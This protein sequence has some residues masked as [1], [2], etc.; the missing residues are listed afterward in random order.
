MSVFFAALVFI[1]ITAQKIPDKRTY[2]YAF[3]DKIYL[4]D[5]PEK[6]LI[7][8]KD[9]VTANK[10][11]SLIKSELN[12]NYSVQSLDENIAAIDL[13]G[14]QKGIGELLKDKMGDIVVV[15]PAYKYQNQ[16]MYYGNEILA[17]PKDGLSISEVVNRLGLGKIVKVKEGKLFSILEIAPTSDAFD[18]ANQIQESGMVKYSYPDFKMSVQ[19][20]QVIPNDTYFSNQFYLQ[21]TGQT[22][23]SIENHSGT[24]A[25]DI[26]AP[27]AWTSTTGNNNIIVA[28]LD[29]GLTP[30][31]PD[32]PN[33]RQVRLNGSNFADGDPNDP[34][35]SD[36]YHANH[37]N[38]CAGIIAATQ[39]N[40]EGISGIAPGVRIMPVRITRGN[41]SNDWY[42]TSTS[43]LASAI[44]FAW[45]SGAQVISNSWELHTDNPNFAPAIVSAIYRAVTQG[46][47]GLGSVVVFAAG[48]SASRYSNGNNGHVSFPSNVQINGVLTVG[49]SDRYDHQADYSP[50]S[51]LSSSNNQVI[52]IVAP[53]NKAMP[54]AMSGI[55]GETG[56]IYTIDIPGY[57]GMNQWNDPATPIATV[58]EIFPGS[59]PNYL[60]YTGRMGGTSASCPQVAAVAALILSLNNNLTQ[61]QVYDIITQSA[62][63]VGGYSYN[64]SGWSA[65]FGNGRLNAYAAVNGIPNRYPV[66]GNDVICTNGNAT[67]SVIG[68]PAGSAT[69]WTSSNSGV[70]TIS[71]SG[72]ASWA[73]SGTV[74]FTATS[75]IP[76]RGGTAV[77]Q[78]TVT[79]GDAIFVNNSVFGD[80]SVCDTSNPYTIV[81]LPA[82]ASVYWDATPL[83]VVT[84]NTPNSA[85]TTL[86]GT[87]NGVITLTAYITN[88]CSGTISKSNI[89]VTG[90]PTITCQTLGNG[91]CNQMTDICPS[92]LY[93]W[94]YF[95][96]PNY[97]PAGA[98][99]F[100]LTVTGSGYFNGGATVKNITTDYWDTHDI[101][102]FVSGNCDITVRPVNNCG[103]SLYVP[104][105]VS[106][107]V[108]YTCSY[109]YSVS[110][111]PATS[112]L[113][114][115]PDPQSLIAQNKTGKISFVEVEIVDKLGNF[116]K[117][118]KFPVG[119]YAATIDV[120]YL[121]ADTYII[122]VFDG[123]NWEDHKILVVK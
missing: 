55:P 11:I 66:S 17:E 123:T 117:R 79:V 12:D 52:D 35:A 91:T 118:H 30:D 97:N 77:S 92:Q 72:L 13:K 47:N 61:Q 81:N 67:F 78:K 7:R 15:R 86:T 39:N 6:Y 24:S 53:S 74:T 49:A 38:A 29:Q 16:L 69:E 103:V 14:Y 58:G 75:S 2:Y 65:E 99:G 22:F 4:D 122:R 113:T 40:S 1:V 106:Y 115:S 90:P 94:R 93:I 109:S 60:S 32:L 95:S 56:E 108:G 88:G 119:T 110:P 33:S 41:L 27:W 42:F 114:I 80:N 50:T 73:G 51:N 37:G 112:S 48:N 120:S 63:K 44:D 26:N 121:T 87:A 98:T 104:Y 20:S 18:V 25:A 57:A 111:N 68:L 62:E 107:R 84:I 59:G 64:T 83:G 43:S 116:K 82:G 100:K 85:Q 46:R 71:S 21:N 102:V 96:I 89:T 9:K 5:V 45:Q 10:N 23:N 101:G 8:F 3:N 70:A 36:A 28:V 54:P 76:N 31:H 105:V 19:I 34:S